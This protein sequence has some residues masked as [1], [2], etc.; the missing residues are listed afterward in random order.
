MVY[1]F[2]YKYITFFSIHVFYNN[3]KSNVYHV[4]FSPTLIQVYLFPN[5]CI[6][7]IQILDL[8]NCALLIFL[9]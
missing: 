5:K 2:I 4:T 3:T 1:I 6:F 7:F 8:L 9:E